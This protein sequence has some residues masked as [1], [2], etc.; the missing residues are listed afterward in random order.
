M[1]D[2]NASLAQIE[3]RHVVASWNMYA[4][5]ERK[6]KPYKHDEVRVTFIQN[7]IAPEVYIKYKKAATTCGRFI[8]A[9]DTTGIRLG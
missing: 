7:D 2:A 8:C 5:L 4:N 6:H 3:R 9:K 1:I